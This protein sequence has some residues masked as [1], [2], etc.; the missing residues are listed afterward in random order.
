MCNSMLQ[1][2]VNEYYIALHY[3]VGTRNLLAYI[4]VDSLN[5]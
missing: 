3:F 4:V 5:I 2:L 1:R